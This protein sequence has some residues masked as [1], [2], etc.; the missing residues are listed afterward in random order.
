MKVWGSLHK[1]GKA[2]KRAKAESTKEDASEALM[3]CLESV[4]KELDVAEPVWVTKHA[5]ELSRSRRT[6]FRQD[7]FLEKIWFDYLEIEF[8]E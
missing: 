2:I 1:D 3:E 7:D 5:K 4:Y 6:K 8:Y